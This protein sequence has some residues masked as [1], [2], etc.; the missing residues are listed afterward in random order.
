MLTVWQSM[1]IY[2]AP[3]TPGDPLSCAMMDLCGEI[4]PGAPY[5]QGRPVITK[6]YLPPCLA[7]G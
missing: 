5:A 4:Y 6:K 7:L 1:G 3:H 2:A